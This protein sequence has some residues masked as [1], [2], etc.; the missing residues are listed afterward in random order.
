MAVD[1]TGAAYLT[2]ET[3]S[4]NFP[5][6]TL[7]YDT[8]LTGGADAFVAQLS[9]DGSQLL[10]GSYLGGDS[11]DRGNAIS[12][13][14]NG[15]VFVTGTTVSTDFPVTPGAYDTLPNGDYDA[16]VTKLQATVTAE[17]LHADFTAIPSAGTVPLS[18]TFNNASVGD[19]Q[20]S[21]WQ[22]GDGYTSTLTNPVHLYTT[23]GLY[24]V[25]L[26]IS[27][28]IY[29]D[30]ELKVGYISVAPYRLYLPVT[31]R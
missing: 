7:A 29:I 21:Y 23:S 6:T 25:T 16:F 22:F 9:A 8:S 31:L 4:T 1:E 13:F 27:N 5:T 30:T 10:Y 11:T 26:T 18:V 2:G 19:Y 12:G 28:T 3:T 17:P 15:E 20:S 14:A 24:T